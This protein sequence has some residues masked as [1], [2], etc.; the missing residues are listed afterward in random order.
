M[1]RA[2]RRIDFT[3]T[4]LESFS[5]KDL[6][7]SDRAAILK[8]L[9]LLDDDEQHPS[10]RVHKLAGDREGSWSA[11]A[12]RVLRLTFERLDAG[13]KRMLTCSKHYDR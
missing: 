2:Y 9:R 6:T 8:A 12:S 4:F 10:L 5:S 7:S 3:D 1:A 13:R 11:S